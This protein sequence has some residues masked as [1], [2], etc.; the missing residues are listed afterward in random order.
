MMLGEQY[1]RMD[2]RAEARA[3][4][5]LALQENA[6]L[7][8]ARELLAGLLLDAGEIDR[9]F[10]VLEPLVRNAPDRFEVLALLGRGYFHRKDYAKS[11]ELLE[12]AITLRRPEP[13]ILNALAM[14]HHELG[15]DARAAEILEQS[16]SLNPDQ[17]PVRD[18][19]EKPPERD[20]GERR[21]SPRRLPF[22]LRERGELD[23][24]LRP[25]RS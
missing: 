22:L 11:I 12:K 1:L 13:E 16:L 9:V 14:S 19:L 17:A 23:A 3:R 7:G 4:L 24:W 20:P 10:T 25:R 8:P 2:A 6:Q 18:L 15:N 21:H 5:E